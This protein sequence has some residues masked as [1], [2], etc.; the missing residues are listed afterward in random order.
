M[1]ELEG[2]GD[3]SFRDITG[4]DRDLVVRP[5]KV[6]LGNCSTTQSC[7]EI[8][9]MRDGVS[10]RKSGIVQ[11]MIVSTGAGVFL[12]SMCSGEDE[13]LE[14]GRMMPNCSIW[15]NS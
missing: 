6:D 7:S 15:S 12:G 5:D 13:A 11:C 2:C 4:L 14:E 8:L 1:Q 9:D 10:I 3:S